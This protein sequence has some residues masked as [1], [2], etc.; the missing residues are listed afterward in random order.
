MRKGYR[1]YDVYSADGKLIERIDPENQTI[2][3]YYDAYGNSTKVVTRA[4]NQKETLQPQTITTIYDTYGRKLQ[5]NDPDKGS[6]RYAYNSFGELVEQ[7]D[8]KQQTIVMNYDSLGRMISRK[9]NTSLS[10]WTY[11]TDAGL[12]NRGKPLAV[13]QWSAL[14]NCNTQV[15][16]EYAEHYYYDDFGRPNKTDFVIGANQYQTRIE[17][18][19]LGQISRQHYPTST[20]DFYIDYEYNDNY[21][22]SK[23]IDNRGKTLRTVE[24]MDAFGNITNQSFGNGTS[25]VKTFNESTGRIASIDVAKTNG[26]DIHQLSYGEF[27][28]KGNV[29]RRSHSYYNGGILK[30]GFAEEFGYDKLNRMT[31]RELELNRG[32]LSPYGQDGY[33]ERYAYD[34]FGNIKSKQYDGVSSKHANYQYV[35]SGSVNRLDSAVVDGKHYS[36]FRYDNNGNTVSDGSRSFTYNGFD[37]VRRIQQGTQYTEYRYN[38]Q[39]AVYQAH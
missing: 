10:C 1:Y 37:K 30:L 25:E 36:K 23:Q 27:D 38:H 12:Y 8:A 2:S 15:K 6:W 29:T 18:N 28:K 14:A 16:P 39:R 22:L 33:V 31:S 26:D 35:T 9:D 7:T 5:T 4:E 34:G 24:A 19:G 20:A 3:Y 13:K 11:G 21:F 17:Y 32:S